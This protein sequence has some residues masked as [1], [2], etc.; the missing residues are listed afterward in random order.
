VTY[1]I[2]TIIKDSQGLAFQTKG[3]ANEGVDQYVVSSELVVGRMVFAI[4]YIGHV[5]SISHSFLGFLFL[6]LIPGVVIICGEV[7][8]IV[9][10]KILI[11]FGLHDKN[12]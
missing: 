8:S 2:V 5:A 1:R 9:K 6:V 12:V 3:D 7:V 10:K 4:P 11:Q